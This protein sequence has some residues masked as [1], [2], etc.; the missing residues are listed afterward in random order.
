MKRLGLLTPITVHYRP[1]VPFDGAIDSYGIVAGA[2]RLEAAKRLGW[3]DIAVIEVTG[4][5]IE[6]ELQEIAENLHR[7]ELTVLERD[8][9]VARWAELLAAKERQVDAPSGGAQPADK[10][11]KKAAR[12]LNISEPDARR[13]VKVASISPEAQALAR[14]AGLDDNR[15]ALLDIAK[16]TTPQA[17][18]AKVAEIAMAKAHA[19][20]ANRQGGYTSVV[21][22]PGTDHAAKIIGR[23]S[24]FAEFCRTIS[25]ATIASALPPSEVSAMQ[26][27]IA[28]IDQWLA[29]FV[30]QLPETP[31]PDDDDSD[32]SPAG[33]RAWDV[34]LKSRKGRE[35]NSVKS[36]ADRAEERASR[37]ATAPE[38]HRITAGH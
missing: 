36:A 19:K 38:S 22:K 3:D 6:R 24:L 12:E 33:T 30:V 14:D 11:I 13:A 26:N 15:S 27:D 1:D 35:E 10:G 16:E 37:A 29:R 32:E 21:L 8:T 18:V 5:E 9:Q 2:H 23:I 34:E 28:V 31:S 4:D 20:V 17:Q 25:P 7:A